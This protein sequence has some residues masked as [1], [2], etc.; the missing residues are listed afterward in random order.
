LRI[1][2]NIVAT[3]ARDKSINSAVTRNLEVSPLEC[4]VQRS[5]DGSRQVSTDSSVDIN[6]FELVPTF[7]ERQAKVPAERASVHPFV[8]CA[9]VCIHRQA[10][11]FVTAARQ[12]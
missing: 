9:V 5:P 10:P 3:V 7:H 8:A 12:T 2:E 6:V 1:A 11:N 4:L